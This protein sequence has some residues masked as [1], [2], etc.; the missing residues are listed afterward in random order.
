[1]STETVRAIAKEY[2]V[3]ISQGTHPKPAQQ[4]GSSAAGENVESMT[5][6]YV[7]LRRAWRRYLDASHPDGSS[8]KPSAVNAITWNESL[9]H[10][11][12][13]P[14]MSSA[15]G[16]FAQRRSTMTWPAKMAA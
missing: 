9:R 4:N 16:Q 15:R 2:L 10:G 3:Q 1:M 12:T 8:R 5:S 6:V 14:C 7:V 13:H 11:W